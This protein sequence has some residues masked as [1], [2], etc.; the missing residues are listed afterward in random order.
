MRPATQ[1]VVTR[2]R[3]L[4]ARTQALG[5]ESAHRC[6]VVR[7]LSSTYR[8]RESY[9]SLQ[10]LKRDCQEA[11]GDPDR[12]VRLARKLEE[13][14]GVDAVI[15]HIEALPTPH[16]SEAVLREYLRA[17]ASK[18]SGRAKGAERG[19]AGFDDTH[20]PSPFRQMLGPQP[21]V[22]GA[23]GGIGAGGRGPS[24]VHVAMS[25]PSSKEQVWR[26]LRTLAGAYLLLLGITTIMEERGLV[27]VS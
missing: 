7:S 27:K 16:L 11:P 4:A 8:R 3:P 1:W 17:L 12:Q 5:A 22:A 10:S 25:E 18:A 15:A 9:R 24:A 21:G 20:R 19:E 26:T 6:A 23:I 14:Q 13:E 2:S